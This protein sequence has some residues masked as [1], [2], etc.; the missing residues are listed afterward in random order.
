MVTVNTGIG[1]AVEIVGERPLPGYPDV[2]GH[3]IGSRH[4]DGI[5]GQIG[6][7]AAVTP[8]G[9]DSGSYR[10]VRSKAGQ[11]RV[12]VARFQLPQYLVVRPVFFGDVDDVFDG[13]TASGRARPGQYRQRIFAV[14][15]Y[16]NGLVGIGDYLFGVGSQSVRHWGEGR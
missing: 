8:C 1:V 14:V 13:R 3:H 10:H 12:T 5:D 7:A 6:G 11:G 15:G 9:I 2:V 4:A 16:S